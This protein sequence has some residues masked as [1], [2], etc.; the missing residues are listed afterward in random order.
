FDIMFDG[1]IS[2]EGDLVELAASEGIVEKTG[3]WF[4]YGQIR[5]GQGKENA[6]QFMRDNPEL[7]EE[8]RKAVL[9]KWAAAHAAPA[10]N[11]NGHPAG[12]A[13]KPGETP[14]TETKPESSKPK[15]AGKEKAAPAK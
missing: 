14:A 2:T 7:M 12:E 5:I 1:G 4:S 13:A 10:P 9:A 3:A 6:K 15:S 11:G 8:I